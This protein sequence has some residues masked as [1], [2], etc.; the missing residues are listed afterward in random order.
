MAL[1]RPLIEHL[2]AAAFA[3]PTDAPEADG[4]YSWSST[5]MVVA[6][7]LGSRILWLQLSLGKGT[8]TVDK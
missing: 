2:E 1:S 7:A 3:V 6:H 5:T 8:F 4:M